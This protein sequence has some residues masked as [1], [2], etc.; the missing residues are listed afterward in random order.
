MHKQKMHLISFL[1]RLLTE[2]SN[3]QEGNSEM[4]FY[5]KK[6][7]LIRMVINIYITLKFIN[8]KFEG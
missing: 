4:P 6:Y 2:R 3:Y 1:A 7:N 5:G 8:A